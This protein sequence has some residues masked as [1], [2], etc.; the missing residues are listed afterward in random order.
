LAAIEVRQIVLRAC[1]IAIKGTAGL[2]QGFRL[3]L[4]QRG[5]FGIFSGPAELGTR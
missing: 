1:D 4:R 3:A 5:R 2:L